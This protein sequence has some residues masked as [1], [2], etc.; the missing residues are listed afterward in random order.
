MSNILCPECGGTNK[1]EENNCKDCNSNLILNKKYQLL[2]TLGQNIGTTYKAK[3]IKGYGSAPIIS[4]YIIKELSLRTLDKWKTEELFQRE[5]STLS[6]LN[7]PS[8]PNFIENFS[9][10]KGRNA[11]MYLVMEFFEGSN[12]ALERKTKK[13]TSTQA[14]KVMKDI[15]KTLEYL[16]SF[17]PPII[18]R[19]LKPSNLVRKKDGSI[20]IIDFGSVIDIIQSNGGSTIAGTFA[21]MPPEQVLGL[22]SE[23]SDYY[24]LAVTALALISGKEPE[25]MLEN[26]RLNWKKHINFRHKKLGLFFENLLNEDPQK[27]LNSASKI[28]K[29]IDDLLNSK[30]KIQKKKKVHKIKTPKIIKVTKRTNNKKPHVNK[31]KEM[32]PQR[33]AKRIAVIYSIFVT[34]ILIITAINGAFLKGLL[35]SG[36]I[37]LFSL[38]LALTVGRDKW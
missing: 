6:K 19:D 3:I 11:K 22:A 14:L 36:G 13:Y 9:A 8:I 26:R 27:R 2:K 29:A 24:S 35:F 38:F 20:G 34:P 10:G 28:I 4:F 12:L 7:H 23:V 30:K 18:H 5:I 17:H 25:A 15:A 31:Y 32:T 21:Y 16:H 37:V 33:Q 1:I